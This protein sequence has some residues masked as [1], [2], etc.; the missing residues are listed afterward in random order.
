MATATHPMRVT[1]KA[2]QILIVDDEPNIVTAIEF[3]MQQCG[4]VTEKAHNGQEAIEKL[5]RFQPDLILLD[6]MMPLMDGLEVAHE[7]RKQ[8]ELQEARIVFLTAKSADR[9]RLQAY[10]AGADAY[11]TKPF[12]NQELVDRVMEMLE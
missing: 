4:F 3:L 7:I 10:G 2:A 8:P 9:D 1:G 12:D 11:L 5:R 6:V